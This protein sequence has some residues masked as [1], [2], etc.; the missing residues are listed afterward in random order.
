MGG[1][2][3]MLGRAWVRT[4]EG[5]YPLFHITKLMMGKEGRDLTH[6]PIGGCSRRRHCGLFEGLD[7]SKGA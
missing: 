1:S 6:L 2:R 7:T 4:G 3:L 5:Q